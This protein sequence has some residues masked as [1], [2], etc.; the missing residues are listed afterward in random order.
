M[1]VAAD[2]YL[3]LGVECKFQKSVICWV[4]AIRHRGKGFDELAC[5]CQREKEFAA[6]F[7]RKVTVKFPARNDLT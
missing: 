2:N 1:I 3:G 4:D 6:A 5:A 7:S